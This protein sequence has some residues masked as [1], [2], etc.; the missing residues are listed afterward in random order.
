MRDAPRIGEQPEERAVVVE[1]L[2]EM[3]NRPLGVDAVAAKA[4]TQLIVDAAFAHPLERDERDVLFALAQAELQIGRMR[5]FRRAA[6]TAERG[7]EISAQVLE[8]RP[9]DVGR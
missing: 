8:H 6:E 2:L 7:I 5:E 3:R 9:H 4:A 1:H